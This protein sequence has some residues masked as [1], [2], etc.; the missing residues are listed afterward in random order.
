MNLDNFLLVVGSVATGWIGSYFKNKDTKTSADKDITLKTY[1]ILETRMVALEQTNAGQAT[2]IDELKE[3][4]RGLK[5]NYDAREHSYRRELEN[6]ANKLT[7]TENKLD[8]AIEL[9][10]S[11]NIAI[12]K[13]IMP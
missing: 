2:I 11:N 8:Q 4:L 6:I 1:D 3:Q 10:K 7:A 13:E 12:A 9:L 5:A